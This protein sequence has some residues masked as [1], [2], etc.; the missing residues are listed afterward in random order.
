[1]LFLY[2]P[3]AYQNNVFKMH[4]ILSINLYIMISYI[5]SLYS[6]YVPL[7]D[8]HQVYSNINFDIIRFDIYT[9]ELL[10]YSE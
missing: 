5:K 1:M 7:A 10:A 6:I 4:Y 3:T 9:Y 2:S 8:A